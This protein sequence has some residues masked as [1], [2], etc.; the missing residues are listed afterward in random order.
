MNVYLPRNPEAFARADVG[1]FFDNVWLE[2]DQCRFTLRER[3]LL[4][5]VML[6]RFLSPATRAFFLYHFS[7]IIEKAVRTIFE[8]RPAPRILELGC[9][10]GTMSLLFAL[11]GAEVIGVDLDPAVV[12]ACRKRQ[13][14]YESYAGKLRLR[15]EAADAF[16][17]PYRSA[18]PLDVVYSLFAF[19]MMQP[20]PRLLD[21]IRPAL[22]P[23]GLLFIS[24]GN[25]ASIYNRLFRSR[26]SLTPQGMQSALVERGFAPLETTYQCVLPA[27]LCRS[28]PLFRVG[29]TCERTLSSLGLMP[30]LGVSYNIVAQAV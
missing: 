19:N 7:P 23:G 8:R 22:G 21:L 12:R 4:D 6:G 3:D 17:F 29:Q 28:A 16:E 24:D 15:F 11:L 20:T 27:W 1:L 2:I 13:I 18:A 10:S 14:F 26:L 9:G 25:N 30:R 5:G